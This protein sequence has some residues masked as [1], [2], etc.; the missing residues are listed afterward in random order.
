[1]KELKTIQEIKRFLY[2]FKDLQKISRQLNKLSEYSCNVGLTERQDKRED[3]LIKKADEIAKEFN[4]RAY[5]QGDPRGLSLYLVNEEEYL[6][7]SS[8]DYI[9]GIPVY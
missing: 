3:K 2:R 5:Y 4:L 8:C 7:G 6:K 1:M 9:A